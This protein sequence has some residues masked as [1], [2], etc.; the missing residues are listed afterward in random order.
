MHAERIATLTA[1]VERAQELED[2][3]MSKGD[4]YTARIAREQKYRN[5]EDLRQALIE[6][7]KE[8]D[9]IPFNW[10]AR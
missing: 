6:R 2:M 1:A 4:N 10:D 5:A 8:A 3:F 7:N 9:A